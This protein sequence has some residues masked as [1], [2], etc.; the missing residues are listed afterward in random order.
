[1]GKLPV[2]NSDKKPANLHGFFHPTRLNN[3]SADRIACLSLPLGNSLA[4]P[5]KPRKRTVF[6]YYKVL[7]MF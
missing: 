7:L 5:G 4:S 3:G 1:M 2:S 6:G